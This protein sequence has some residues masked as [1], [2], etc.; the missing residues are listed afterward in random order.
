MTVTADL[1]ARPLPSSLP[2]QGA[3]AAHPD[4]GGEA[5][6]PLAQLLKAAGDELRLAILRVLGQSSFGVQELCDVFALR[7]PSMSHHLKVLALAELVDK[8]RE[9]NSIFYR[10]CLP[11]SA[12]HGELLDQIDASDLAPAQQQRLAQVLAG[13]AAQSRAHFARYA[14]DAAT[15]EL[16]ADYQQY[17]DIAT[18][19]LLRAKPEGDLAVEIGPGEGEF[20]LELGRRFTRVVGYD[21]AAP[22]QALARQRIDAAKLQNIELIL[23]EWPAVAPDEAQA[24]AMVLNMVLHHLP[25]PADSLRAAAWRLKPGGV[26]LVTELCRHDQHWAHESCGDLWLGFEEQELLAWAARA[27]LTQLEAQFVAQRNGFQV[28]VRTFVRGE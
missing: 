10:R 21:N 7:Q 4:D 3:A 22:I 8:R 14:D 26:L 23:G 13:R 28:Q 12:L 16:I 20:L 17:A 2:A 9:G 18:E 25:S 24:D 15:E 27:G 5:S 19:L 11:T 1:P 6:V